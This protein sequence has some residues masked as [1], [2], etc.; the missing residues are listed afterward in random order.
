[1]DERPSM[2]QTLP[3]I[4]LPQNKQSNLQTSS[5]LMVIGGV[6]H[7]NYFKFGGYSHENYLTIE[8]YCS[9]TDIW[10]LSDEEIKLS[11]F[12]SFKIRQYALI[13]GDLYISGLKRYLSDRNVSL[14]L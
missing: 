6:N 9:Q 10:T 8:T 11:N 1:M 3:T 7:H 5:K 4:N 12:I 2:K 13:K 14:C